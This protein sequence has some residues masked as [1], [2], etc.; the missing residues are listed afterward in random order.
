MKF[1]LLSDDMESR[2][3]FDI[4]VGS[5]DKKDF[6]SHD[7]KNSGSCHDDQID[8]VLTFDAH[9][10]EVGYKATCVDANGVTNTLW[11]KPR[12]YFL[13]NMALETTV[14]TVC[15]DYDTRCCELTVLDSRLFQDGLTAEHYGEFGSFELLLNGNVIIEY[16]GSPPG[17]ERYEEKSYQFGL[18]C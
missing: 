6:G 3:G 18:G 2:N 9:P 4:D 10:S 11:D 5:H 15:L 8:L 12:G 7:K 1:N 14:E 16:D 17:A 13:P